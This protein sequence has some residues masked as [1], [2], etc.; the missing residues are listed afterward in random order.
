LTPHFKKST[1]KAIVATLFLV[2]VFFAGFAFH[3]ILQNQNLSGWQFLT[4]N[5]S[6]LFERGNTDPH[7]PIRLRIP[8]LNVD[9][10]IEQVSLTSSWVME[11]PK[12][13]ADA[14]WFSMG[15]RP[16]ETGSA[17]I[18]GHYGWKDGI[19]AAFD[20]LHAL[21]KGDE[22]FVERKDGTTVTF[23]VREVLLY[24]ENDD[25]SAIFGSSDG[26]AHLNLI[27]C[28]GIWNKVSKS[29]SDRRVVFADR[30]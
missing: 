2:L 6:T 24:G 4:A 30:E 20:N 23:V 27:T 3:S 29:Y 15:P 16:G 18:A 26:K 7:T 12:I 19:P 17:V 10:K 9:A 13:P 8:G 14:G 5:V 28:E 25:A 21:V 11:A 1:V 22:I